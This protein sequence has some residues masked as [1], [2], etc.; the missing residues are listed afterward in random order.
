MILPHW[1][2]RWNSGF[3]ALSILLPPV[4]FRLGKSHC[5]QF[6]VLG[7]HTGYSEI[8][9]TVVGQNAITKKIRLTNGFGKSEAVG[10]ENSVL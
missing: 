7:T 1:I 5:R 3:S 4:R 9:G 8:I 2:I 6:V 10:R